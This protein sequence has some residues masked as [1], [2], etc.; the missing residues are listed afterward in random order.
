MQKKKWIA[1]RCGPLPQPE[2]PKAVYPD[3][4]DLTVGDPDLPTPPEILEPAFEDARAGHTKYTAPIGDPE[5]RQQICRY[6]KRF[7][8]NLP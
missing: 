1:D 7:S 5:L 4:I 3:L 6:Y 8:C 2:P